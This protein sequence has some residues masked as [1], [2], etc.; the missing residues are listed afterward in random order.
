VNHQ[1]CI[2]LLESYPYRTAKATKNP[3][4]YTLIQN[5][6][7]REQ[8]YKVVEYIRE[9]GELYYFW[10]KPY[11]IFTMNG[12]RYWSM[13]A[14]V[15]ETI[16]INRA[17][18]RYGSAYDLAPDF[19]DEWALESEAYQYA[20]GEIK[21]HVKL[22]NVGR[23]LEVGC[24]TGTLF[25]MITK[26]GGGLPNPENYVGIDPSLLCVNKFREKYPEYKTIPCPVEEYWEGKFDRIYCLMGTASYLLTGTDVYLHDMLNEGGEAY[27]MFYKNRASEIHKLFE[28]KV[29]GVMKQY[30][31]ASYK[32]AD[33]IGEYTIVILKKPYDST[34]QK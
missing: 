30:P 25:D 16:L 28:A 14:P 17:Q 6:K 13:G 2:E 18:H 23:V 19:Y 9:H 21:Q 20:W 10:K 15:K 27:L 24:G 34:H 22:D 12:Y 31:L 5:W 8:F 33:E 1:R 3:H 4:Q 26:D 7:S 29:E 11:L 32:G